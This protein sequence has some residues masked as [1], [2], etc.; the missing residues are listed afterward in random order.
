MSDFLWLGPFIIIYVT[1]IIFI[2]GLLIGSFLNVCIYRIPLGQ[3]IAISRSHCMKCGHV[4][5]WYELIPLFSW[6][7][8]GGKCR[9][10]KEKISIQYPLIETANA[11]AWMPILFVW[12]FRPV[13]ILYCACASVM[14][15]ISVIDERTK[16][17]NLGLNLFIGIL[18]LLRLI[19]DYKNWYYYLIGMAAVSVPFLIIVI[20]SKERAMGLGDVY[21]M[22]A[23]GLLLGWKHVLLATTLGC[24][25]GSIIH[26]IRMKVSKKGSELAFG[27][28]LCLGIYLTIVFG[29]PILRWYISFITNK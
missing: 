20:V 17:I 25:L 16:E 23:A 6:L 18:G 26:I 2:L 14:I 13:T 9:A 1:F 27:P 22:A 8:Q 12:G 5:K 4:L 11:L 21:L 15:V 29:E 3:N 24:A 10:C 28:Y 19:L 7:I